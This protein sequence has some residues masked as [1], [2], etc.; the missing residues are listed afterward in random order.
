MGEVSARVETR[1][2]LFHRRMV[3]I[4]MGIAG[5][6]ILGIGAWASL[7]TGNPVPFLQDVADV[8][9]MAGGTALGLRSSARNWF[10]RRRLVRV[11][12][13]SFGAAMVISGLLIGSGIAALHGAP[14]P[15]PVIDGL[16]A[17]QYGGNYYFVAAVTAIGLAA[18]DSRPTSP[19]RSLG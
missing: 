14:I 9:A 11:A 2:A 13:T 12:A 6:V 17:L 4:V 5:A 19:P 3:T 1:C 18:A 10:D 8:T 15:T 16:S 7:H